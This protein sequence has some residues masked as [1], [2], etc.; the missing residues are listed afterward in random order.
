MPVLLILEAV[1]VVAQL[2]V[3]YYY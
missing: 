1:I 2:N 3:D